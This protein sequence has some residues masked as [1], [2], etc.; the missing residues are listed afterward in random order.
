LLQVIPPYTGKAQGFFERISSGTRKLADG[1]VK[2]AVWIQ[3]MQAV[4]RSI[5]TH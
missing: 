3:Q 2:P 4:V 5:F 1:A